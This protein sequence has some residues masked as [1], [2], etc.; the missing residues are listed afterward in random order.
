MQ[1]KRILSTK[2]SD[3]NLNIDLEPTIPEIKTRLIKALTDENTLEKVSLIIIKYLYLVWCVEDHQ[4]LALVKK[5]QLLAPINSLLLNV[6]N[7]PDQPPITEVALKPFL[8]YLLE[9]V[10]DQEQ[11]CALAEKMTHF[12]IL[13]MNDAMG[14]ALSFFKGS[15]STHL[16]HQCTKLM[17]DML[18]E[19]KFPPHVQNRILL[20]TTHNRIDFFKETFLADCCDDNA[21]S[22]WMLKLRNKAI[23]DPTF[24]IGFS[25][26]NEGKTMFPLLIVFFVCSL[27]ILYGYNIELT[28]FTLCMAVVLP[29]V[30]ATCGS[31]GVAN[32]SIDSVYRSEIFNQD[33]PINTHIMSMLLE[34]LDKLES[35]TDETLLGTKPKK[36][37]KAQTVVTEITQESSTD[38]YDDIS[39]PA[40][41]SYKV[42]KNK[43]TKADRVDTEAKQKISEKQNKIEKKLEASVNNAK[44]R[45][46]IVWRITVKQACYTFIY[47]PLRD[48]FKVIVLRTFDETKKSLNDC[49]YIYW[50]QNA[51][52]KAIPDKT[53]YGKVFRIGQRGKIAN[54]FD[55]Q[56]FVCI[57][58]DQG[59][60]VGW[61]LKCLGKLTSHRRLEFFPPIEGGKSITD[62]NK[63]IYLFKRAT[64]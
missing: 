24:Y 2:E 21:Q 43:K 64:K 9:I 61:K 57:Y 63:Q 10:E 58:S 7:T 50:D 22:N 1:V 15:S 40:S 6:L 12:S 34:K 28:F 59:E 5:N 14:R 55:D 47:R 48:F 13:S 25:E 53:T 29:I 49:H 20:E 60:I 39:Y 26:R 62:E 18:K 17:E 32:L 19:L 35:L 37:H 56:G 16:I 54:P 52:Q 11:N 38:T 4:Y 8:N 42:K 41:T 31:K 27:G 36:Q 33:T 45:E 46:P 44:Q 51:I 23:F 30:L 3:N